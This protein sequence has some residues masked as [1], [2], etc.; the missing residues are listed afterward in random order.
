MRNPDIAYHNEAGR[1]AFTFDEEKHMY[2]LTDGRII[3]GHT[4][5]LDLGG[6]V[7]YADIEPDILERKSAIGREAHLAC[8]FNDQDKRM[9]CDPRVEGYLFAWRDF[10]KVT[11]F[12]PFL[13]EYRDVYQIN[14]LDFGM[15]IDR[16]GHYPHDKQET[17]IELKT[18]VQVMPH[19]GVQL[20]AQA[21]G[22]KHS[23][24]TS[25]LARFLV[26]KREVIQL[27]ATGKWKR[28][29]FTESYDLAMFE[30]A[31][32]TTYWKLKHEKIYFRSQETA[33]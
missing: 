4:R 10:R 9:T 30:H 20:A 28:H 27:R 15:Q 18:C 17:V 3:P 6:L 23:G 24:M 11:G 16:L 1:L 22:V 19:H 2:R 29:P 21:G 7:P 12:V 14:G 33:F 5:V 26:R 32:A 31:L 25:P 8:L 13:C